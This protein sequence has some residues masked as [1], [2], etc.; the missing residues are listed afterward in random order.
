MKMG[1]TYLRLIAGGSLWAALLWPAHA[2]MI[3]VDLD[4]PPTSESNG[5]VYRGRVGSIAI[6]ARNGT[7]SNMF[8]HVT[9]SECWG[10]SGGCARFYGS[11]SGGGVYRGFSI[12][13]VSGGDSRKN[14]R[15]LQKWN[16]SWRGAENLKGNY[17]T[18]GGSPFWTQEKAPAADFGGF[19]MAQS[20]RG[21]VYYL[22]GNGQS[23]SRCASEG[24]QCCQHQSACSLGPGV[25]D[26]GPFEFDAYAEQWVAIELELHS[27]GI[28]RIYLWTQDGRYNGLYMEARDAPQGVP[29][30]TGFSGMY[31]HD[32][33]AASG[34]YVMVD[35]V[36]LSDTFI[37][38]PEGFSDSVPPSPPTEVTLTSAMTSPPEGTSL[39]LSLAAASHEIRARLPRRSMMGVGSD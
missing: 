22:H 10:G 7:P 12:G 24:Y 4:T 26:A 35:E 28:F 5:G 39:M 32:S 36:E 27:S 9:G 18:M 33:G 29:G 25:A 37:G 17:L 31:F 6:E 3:S 11:V 1:M 13:N 34:S 21:T 19:Q 8:D 2:Q 16:R 38:P 20:Y 23:S 30:I 15:F 14:L